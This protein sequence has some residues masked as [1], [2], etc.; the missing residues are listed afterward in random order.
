MVLRRR[1]NGDNHHNKLSHIRSDD[2][3]NA[4]AH[5]SLEIYQR[6][7]AEFRSQGRSSAARAPTDLFPGV[8]RFGRRCVIHHS[9]EIPFG[10]NQDLIAYL[11]R[12][13][14]WSWRRL[15]DLNLS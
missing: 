3:G 2:V 4:V 7:T 1:A 15:I 10:G 6:G 8:I 5:R 11:P 9:R 12:D 13:N 14:G